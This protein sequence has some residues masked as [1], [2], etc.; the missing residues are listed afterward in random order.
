MQKTSV[1]FQRV[2]KGKTQLLPSFSSSH[3]NISRYDFDYKKRQNEWTTTNT[4]T[5]YYKLVLS[6]SPSFCKQLPSIQRNR[7]F[8]CQY[9]DVGLI[10]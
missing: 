3:F 1:D 10:V 7:T 4:K 9:D 2:G 6:W 8:Q 5:D